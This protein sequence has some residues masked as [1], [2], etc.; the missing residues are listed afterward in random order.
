MGE[1]VEHQ[2]A[3]G[4]HFEIFNTGWAGE[5][6]EFAFAGDEGE[7]DDGLET[8]GVFFCDGDILCFAKFHEVVESIVN[9][10]DVAVEHGCV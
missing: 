10:F 7:W 2:A 4:E 3:D 9:G 1:V 6:F 5:M 8:S